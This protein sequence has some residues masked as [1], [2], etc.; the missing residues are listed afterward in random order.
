MNSSRLKYEG[1]LYWL[2]FLIAL[3]LRIVQLGATPLTDSESQFALQALHLAQGK[4]TLLGPQPAY[5][6]FT[7][8]LYRSTSV[9]KSNRARRL[10]LPFSLPSTPA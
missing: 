8:I 10:S 6:L 3:G 4:D 7:S 9:K 2:A 1:W 5:I